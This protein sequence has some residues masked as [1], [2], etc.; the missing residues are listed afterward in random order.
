MKPRKPK[1]PRKPATPPPRAFAN[2]PTLRDAE[3]AIRRH[4]KKPAHPLHYDPALLVETERWWYIPYGWI[5][6]GGFIV[7]KHDLAIN[8]LGSALSL[9]DSFWGHD[10][11]IVCDPVDF[12][13]TADIKPHWNTVW[14][15]VDRFQRP[16]PRFYLLG[17][18]YDFYP[19]EDVRPAII[20]QFPTFRAHFVWYAIPILRAAVEARAVSF[21]AER[22]RE[23]ED[24]SRMTCGA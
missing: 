15:I 7:D 8:E 21:Y 13:F 23:D 17:R 10:H 14:D 19:A 5:G 9:E 6:C 3:D 24:A 20:A 2:P 12:T 18:D 11:G 1:P 4:L 16:L 22:A